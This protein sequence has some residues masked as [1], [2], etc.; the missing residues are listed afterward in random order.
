MVGY[1][2]DG[3]FKIPHG[4]RKAYRVEL[5]NQSFIF[6]NA[7]ISDLLIDRDGNQWYGCYMKGLFLSNNDKNV[8]H[9]VTLDELGAGMETISSVVGVAD[10]LMLFV[11]KNHGLYLLDEK[12]G[13][14]PKTTQRPAGLI[15]VYSD[16][17]KKVYV[18]A[19]EGIYEYDWKHQTYRLLL[20]ANGLS[21][22]GMQVDA[23]GNM[24]LT[25]QGNGLY[26]W[27]R[28]S[29]KMTQ[30]LMDDRRPHKTIC[31]NWITDIRLDSRGRLLVCNNQWCVVHGSQN[32]IF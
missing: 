1:L 32:R 18:Y 27:N 15:K 8:F 11:V 26:V 5:N 16:F 12:T 7:H 29:G 28:K 4:S 30:Y 3:S 10:G 9:S 2:G 25:S 23:A 20:L 19:S 17:R 6:D 24:Y 14:T 31:N 13:K 22:D 21:L